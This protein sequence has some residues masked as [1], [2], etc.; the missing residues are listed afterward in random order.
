VTSNHWALALALAVCGFWMVGAHNRIVGLR[1]A[2]AEAWGRVDP[3]LTRRDAALT[4]LAQ[5]LWE[6]WPNGRSALDALAAA[7]QQLHSTAQAVRQRP[8]RAV[9][10]ASLAAAENALG[11]T[12]ARLLNQIEA[13]PGLGTHDE[14][15]AQL[16]TLFALGPQLLEARQRFNQASTVYNRA[17]RQFPTRLL[18]PVFRFETAGSF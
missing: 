16:L 17:I 7:R 3:L 5:H 11:A 1:A 13:E 10:V 14:V 4:Q 8:A 6:L 15:A 18:V 2:I 9:P 12:I